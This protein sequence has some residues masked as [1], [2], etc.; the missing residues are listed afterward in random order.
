MNYMLVFFSR[1]G[2]TRKIAHV[3]AEEL[4]CT[5][6]DVKTS[7]P[8]VSSADMLVV[9]SGTYGSKPGKELVAF[10]ESLPTVT[11]KKA[12]CF[13]SCGRDASKTLATMQELLVS[14][15]YAIADC[16]SCFGQASIFMRGHPTADEVNQAKEWARKLKTTT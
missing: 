7:S 13:S 12:A 1:G 9:G 14:K 2:S 4:G 3:I 8:D 5:A 16:F 11:G 6:V 10:L 15:G